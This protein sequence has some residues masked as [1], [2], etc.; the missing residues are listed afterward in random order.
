[1]NERQK[2]M[3]FEEFLTAEED[4]KAAWK[5]LDRVTDI[6]GEANDVLDEA[7]AE[8]AYIREQCHDA[9]VFDNE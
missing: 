8:L 7:K 5:E 3:M 1:M 2:E 9:G 6:L 4:V